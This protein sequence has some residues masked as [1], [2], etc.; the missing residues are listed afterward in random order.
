MMKL[1]IYLLSILTI[2]LF[3]VG[4]TE[5]NPVESEEKHFEAIGLYVISDGDT[6]V[7]YV[8]GVVA[9]SIDVQAGQQTSLLSI[10]F[11]TDAGEIDIPQGEESSLAWN[12]TDVTV[13]DIESQED[14]L[15]AY[16]FRISGIKAGNTEITIIINHNDHKDFESKAIPIVVSSAG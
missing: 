13:A 2:F 16:Q 12:I 8:D 15:N 5:D 9:G 3:V 14:E 11:L 7:K 4:C 10:R 6:I 1:M